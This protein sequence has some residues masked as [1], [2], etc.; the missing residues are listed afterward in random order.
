MSNKGTLMLISLL[1][2]TAL[3]YGQIA[4]PA[5]K[6]ID[7]TITGILLA[8]PDKPMHMPTDVAVD[9]AGRVFVADGA[10]DQIVVFDAKG[11]F[12]FLITQPGARKLSGP[13]AL[14]VDPE[15]QLWIADT[16]N[17]RL[18]VLTARGK[19]VE[20]IDLP[21]LDNATHQPRPTGLAI[22]ADAKRTYVVDS[23]NHRVMI[24][25]NIEKQWISLGRFGRSLGQFQWPF[26]VCIGLENYVY[27]TEVIGARVQRISPGDR[28]SGRVGRWG[29]QLGQLYRPKGI[30][31]DTAGRIFVS[32]STLGVV[33]VFDPRGTI[34][35]VLTDQQG[36][37][38]RFDHPMGMCFDPAGN[39][40]VVELGANRVAIVSLS[41]QSPSTEV[42]PKSNNAR[43]DP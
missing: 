38:L 18:L 27:I 41:Q 6:R 24:R 16:G 7:A 2:W 32:D 34:Q 20:Q 3:A 17:H 33:Q 25:D 36:Q 12:D 14:T 9:P 21:E 22:T 31:A 40:Y 28:W 5:D 39:L 23:A 37:V 4:V 43:E 26:M 19:F 15:N 30:V 13:V 10:N 29:V 42:Q 35:G 8:P 1:L 11:Q